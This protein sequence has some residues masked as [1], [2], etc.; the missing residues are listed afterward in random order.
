MIDPEKGNTIEF[1]LKK[2]GFN[3]THTEKEIIADIGSYPGKVVASKS[4]Q[5]KLYM[6]ASSGAPF[7]LTYLTGLSGSS[8]I[9]LGSSNVTT[10]SVADSQWHHYA[11]TVSHTGSVITAKLYVDGEYDSVTTSSAEDMFKVSTILEEQLQLSLRYQAAFQGQLM[12][13]D[14]GKVFEIQKK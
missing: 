6:T 11:V 14:F 1:W 12:I 13:L 8:D 10:S 5:M 2:D 3:S 4:A 7:R 9:E